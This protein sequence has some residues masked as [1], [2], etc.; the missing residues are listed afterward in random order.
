MTSFLP[1]TSIEARRRQRDLAARQAEYQ[2]NYEYVS[3]LAMCDHVPFRDEFAARW[4]IE[5]GKRLL[6][7]LA[8]IAEINR[9]PHLRASH[10]RLNRVFEGISEAATFD[11]EGLLQTLQS[12]IEMGGALTRPQSYEEYATLFRMI[13]LPPIHRDYRNDDV[14]AEMRVA[15]P[16]P[17]MLRRL[18]RL[19]DRF[20]VTDADL[21]RSLPDDSLEAA[22]QEGR[23]YLCDYASLEQLEQSD[24][25]IQKFVYAPLAL[26]VVAK[27]TRRLTAVAIQCRQEPGPDNPVFTPDDGYNW[28]I[29]KT[30]VGMADGNVHEPVTHLAR[31]HLFVEPF[32]MATQRQLSSRHPVGI[33]LRPHFEGTLHIND[34]AQRYLIAPK[35]GVHRLCAGSIESIRKL[36]VQGVQEYAFNDVMLPDTFKQRGVDDAELLPHYPFRDDALLYWDAI[37]QWVDDYLSIYYSSD[38]DVQ[39]D[40]ELQNW[41]REL[42]AHDGARVVGFGEAGQLTTLAYLKQAL[43][44]IIY[45]SSVQ[46]AAV[47]FP[48]YDLMSYAPAMPLAC[49]AEAPTSKQ[50]ATERDFLNI[51]PPLE[52]ANLQASLGYGLGVL[53]YTRLGDYGVGDF[54]DL[55]VVPRA[56]QFRQRIDQIGSIIE[57]RNRQRRPYDFLLP[58]GIPQSINI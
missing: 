15:G 24:F 53:H 7:V 52:L 57:Q 48:Q 37:G 56:R 50:G 42:I 32:V 36:A 41:F 26:F 27:T 34:M 11:L 46:H 3:P 51:L 30:I 44:L 20:P 29:A 43:R 33:L 1:Q 10:E 49:Y 22:A 4:V 55:R 38:T 35:G 19:D 17:V 47:N 12:A 5:I 21:H 8:N 31:T 23:L 58:G 9:D 13:G 14:F 2:Y 54:H 28:L 18:D 39:A 45:T 16:N 40:V 6:A 25:P